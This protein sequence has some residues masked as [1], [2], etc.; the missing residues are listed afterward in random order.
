MLVLMLLP[1]LYLGAD[2]KNTS[3]SQQINLILI[4]FYQIQALLFILL[5]SNCTDIL[6]TVQ[7]PKFYILKKVFI[8]VIKITMLIYIL[9]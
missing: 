6:E 4:H 7:S 9:F 8:L 2:K 3:Q 1:R 5:E